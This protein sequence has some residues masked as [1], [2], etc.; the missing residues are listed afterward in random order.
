MHRFSLALLCLGVLVLPMAAHA[1]APGHVT[2]ITAEV[3]PDRSILIRWQP[4]A[5]PDVASYRM[6]MSRLSILENNGEYDD[7][8]TTDGPVT[9]YLLSEYDRTLPEF[10]VAVLAVNST[11][12]ESAYFVEEVKVTPPP[13]E[14]SSASSAESS[15]PESS[16]VSSESASSESSIM[17]PPPEPVPLPAESGTLRLLAARAVSATRVS[18]EFSDLPTINPSTAAMVFA[19]RDPMGAPLPI[20]QMTQEG[21]ALALQTARQSAGVVYEVRLS[22]PLTSD[23]GLPLDPVDRTAFFSGHP[24]G[25]TTTTATGVTVSGTGGQDITNFTLTSVPQG[26]GRFTISAR[27]SFAGTP[28]ASV[29]VRQSRDG[30]RTFGTPE[31]LAGPVEG[32]EIPNVSAQEY[33]L[34][35]YTVDAEGRAS[36]G[37][38]LSIDPVS[39]AIT[40]GTVRSDSTVTAQVTSSITPAKR[41]PLS[42]TGSGAGMA[43]LLAVG[44]I[45]GWKRMRKI[46]AIA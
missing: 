19:I 2:G 26:D 44:G 38:F 35:V 37:V 5:D 13:A 27:W 24:T 16:S 36:R 42:Q 21:L 33:G 25:I 11:G 17:S 7:F 10:F 18:L 46:Q 40:K 3:Q 43:V 29:V 9:E 1:V 31:M 45:L 15:Q 14:V 30:G 8:E 34:A 22:D 4:V 6:Y 41:T 28:P 12:E 32:A 39:G 20:E 23:N